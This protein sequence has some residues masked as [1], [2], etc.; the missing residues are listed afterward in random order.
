MHHEPLGRLAQHGGIAGTVVK[1]ANGR[2]AEH[3]A[4]TPRD[5]RRAMNDGQAANLGI[6]TEVGE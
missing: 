5:D 2:R 3:L 4:L 6:I 1:P